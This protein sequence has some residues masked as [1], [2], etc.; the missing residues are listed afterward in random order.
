MSDSSHNRE[1][2]P[3]TSVIG[4]VVRSDDFNDDS[5][6]R[7]ETKTDGADV[8]AISAGSEHDLALTADGQVIAAGDKRVSEILTRPPASALSP[9]LL[10]FATS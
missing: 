1:D 6:S 5:G 7:L 4:R 9:S 2:Q 3:V 8:V 10:D